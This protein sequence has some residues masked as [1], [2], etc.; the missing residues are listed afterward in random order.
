MGG[1]GLCVYQASQTNQTKM[2]K[3]Q[4]QN[5]TDQPNQCNQ[6]N[7]QI[8]NPTRNNYNQYGNGYNQYGN[9][10]N[11]NYNRF[12]GQ[13]LSRS[14][15]QG[16]YNSNTQRQSTQLQSTAPAPDPNRHN[17]K[18]EQIKNAKT[19]PDGT[20]KYVLNINNSKFHLI[21]PISKDF[22]L[23][24]MKE[25]YR[26]EFKDP[27]KAGTPYYY[28][29]TNASIKASH[30]EQKTNTQTS[31]PHNEACRKTTSC[32]KQVCCPRK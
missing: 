19:S 26:V 13:T 5:R 20:F 7:Q 25:M 31:T 4:K 9:G 6:P 30:Q 17:D 14:Q 32:L 23:P 1:S 22:Q 28:L 12:Q 16:S 27:F 2:S 8:Q 11:N 15:T 24:E 3:A 29:V 10:Y 21:I 18:L